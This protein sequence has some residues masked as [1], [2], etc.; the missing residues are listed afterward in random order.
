MNGGAARDDLIVPVQMLRFLAAFVV[1]AGHVEIYTYNLGRFTGVELWRPAWMSHSAAGVDLFFAISGFVMV[2]SMRNKAGVPGARRRFVLRR[3]NRIVPL[4]WMALAF[5]VAWGWRYGPAADVATTLSAFAFL[6]HPSS[7]AHGRVVPPLEVGWS[8]NY[9]MLFYVLFAACLAA[10]IRTTALRVGAVL[11]AAVGCGAV[12]ALSEPFAT[13]TDP[14]LLE[15]AGGMAIAQLYARGVR[16]PSLA[17]AG[18][19]AL[20]GVLILTDFTGGH[21]A[22]PTYADEMVR[23][24]TWGVGGWLILGAAVL[25][26]MRLSAGR[27][28]AFGG[29]ISY[30]LY[31]LHTPLLIVAQLAWR[32]FG[33]AYGPVEAGLFACGMIV[34]SLGAAV[35][36]HLLIEKPL[37]ARLNAKVR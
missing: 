11:V 18:M 19:V 34:A 1:L 21:G 27:A 13:W 37:L 9:E 6:P 12:F 29:D 3:L 22:I 7:I 5:T 35:M 4:Y 33:L 31:L 16:L 8:L 25:G 23:L 30:A 32:H 36:A 10:P 26:P 2:T 28:W 15:F 24:L 20:A 14:I 17:R